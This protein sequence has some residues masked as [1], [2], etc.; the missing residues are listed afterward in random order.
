MP[1][2]H[3]I[4]RVIYGRIFEDGILH[5]PNKVLTI[6]PSYGLEHSQLSGCSA[7]AAVSSGCHSWPVTFSRPGSQRRRR[8]ELGPRSWNRTKPDEN[9]IIPVTFGD[10]ARDRVA[11]V[12]CSWAWRRSHVAAQVLLTLTVGRPDSVQGTGLSRVVNYYSTRFYL[13]N[14]VKQK[15]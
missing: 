8:P 1:K 14:I 13:M 9:R 7:A 3:S 11:R 4:L 12:R 10:S 5:Q 2:H 15:N 6:V